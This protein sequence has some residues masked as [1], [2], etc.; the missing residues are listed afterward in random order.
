[1]TTPVRSRV[2]HRLYTVLAAQDEQIFQEGE[3]IYVYVGVSA[4]V[5]NTFSN[6]SQIYNFANFELTRY[7]CPTQTCI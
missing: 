2:Q 7:T 4:G 6:I 5:L 1:M 3:F